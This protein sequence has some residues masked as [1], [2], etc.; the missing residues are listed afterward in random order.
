MTKEFSDDL[1]EEILLEMF[2]GY[3][4]RKRNNMLYEDD[5]KV[6]TRLISLYYGT[7]FSKTE[8][9]KVKKTFITRYCNNESKIEGVNDSNYHGK[10]EIKGIRVMY[11]YLHSK[12]IDNIIHTK[13]LSF[14]SS[15]KMLQNALLNHETSMLRDAYMA[16]TGTELALIELHGKLY[17]YSEFPEAA[18]FIRNDNVY[19]RG[20]GIETCD[21]ALIGTQLK[22]VDIDVQKLLDIAPLIKNSGNVQALLEYLDKCV[23][24]KCRLIKIHPFFDGNGRTIR[25]F[26][27]KLLEEIGLPPIY[28]KSTER[29]EYQNAMQLAIGEGNLTA[30]KG[31]YRYKICDSLIELDINDRISKKNKLNF[32]K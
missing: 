26:T 17:T 5:A 27:N 8:F 25:A 13:D 9:D 21:W 24:I 23:E 2:L 16:S 6:P 30:I 10:N 12:D 4:Y 14:G 22:L 20:T 3:K 15:R 7:N 11:E 29:M 32:K 19:I 18:Y 31:F 1:M 28:V